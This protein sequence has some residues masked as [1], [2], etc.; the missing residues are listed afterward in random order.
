MAPQAPS[1]TAQMPVGEANNRA[2]PTRPN[3]A[4]P[5]IV[6]ASSIS[7]RSRFSRPPTAGFTKADLIG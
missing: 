6:T 1:I 7:A 3:S 2:P 4:S 5:P